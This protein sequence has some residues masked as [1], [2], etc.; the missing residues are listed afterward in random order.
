MKLL[1]LIASLSCLPMVASQHWV[2]F[3]TG[4]DGVYVASFDDESGQIGA[5]RRAAEV[6]RPNFLAIHPSQD[7]LYSV[8]RLAED[9]KPRDSAT[10]FSFDRSTGELTKINQLE[11]QGSG[12]CHV[13]VDATGRMISIANYSSG[14]L[15]AM[16]LRDDGGL[17]ANT[18][19]FQHEGS[20]A[21]PRQSSAHTH[22]VNYSPDNRFLI[23]AD[24]GMDQ[25]LVY[26][27][28]PERAALEPH[29]PPFHSIEPGSGPRHF[30]FH[31]NGRFAFAVNELASTVTA[32]EYDAAAGAFKTLQTISTLAADVEVE[33]TTAEILVHPSGRFLYA[34]NRGHNSIAVFSVEP[35]TGRLR[36]VQRASTLGDWPRNFRIAPGGRFLLAANQQSDS[37]VVFAIDAS[38]GRLSPTGVSAKAPSPMCIRFIERR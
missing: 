38:T 21:H 35:E 27:A 31:P 26:R 7:R 3:G 34:S 13:N 15:E 37:V 17:G 36:S 14:S 24:L 5:V 22:S 2:Y 9:G 8:N 20:S 29:T 19:F 16:S 18:S 10:A 1:A 32:L 23:V 33:N 6:T 12:S 4:A 30:T 25:V 28:I 11:T